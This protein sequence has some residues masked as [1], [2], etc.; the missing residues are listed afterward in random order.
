MRYAASGESSL[1]S[2]CALRDG[3]SHPAPDNRRRKYV[4]RM[5]WDFG[6]QC[7]GAGKR[8]RTS[9]LFTALAP[10]A[11]VSTNSTIPARNHLTA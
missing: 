8:T 7:V 3:A 10:K 11:S 6:L 9:M 5:T 4:R 1:T 2:A